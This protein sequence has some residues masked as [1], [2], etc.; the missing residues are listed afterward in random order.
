[1]VQAAP[2][3]SQQHQ[4]RGGQGQE[5]A[6]GHLQDQGGDREATQDGSSLQPDQNHGEDIISWAQGRGVC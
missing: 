1:M 6:A 3:A 4:H 2:E 5:A